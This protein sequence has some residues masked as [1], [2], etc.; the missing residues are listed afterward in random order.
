MK[1]RI[2][3]VLAEAGIASRRSCE[4]LVLQG[5]V[6]VNGEV[7]TRLP[8]M[9]DPEVDQVEIDDQRVQLQRRLNKERVYVLM[10]KP[11]GVYCTNVSQGEQ[12]R[13]IDLLPPD[14]N[15]RVYPVGR[16][17]ADSRG[18]LLLTNDGD[19]TQQLTH[20]KFGV[21]KTYT[22]IVDGFIQPETIEKLSEGIWLSDESGRGF[23]TGKT[24]IKLVKRTGQ[25]SVIQIT[26]KEDRNR[27]VRRMFAR[28]G[29]KVRELTRTKIGTLELGKLEPG[30]FRLLHPHEV[31]KLQESVKEKAARAPKPDKP[32]SKSKPAE[33]KR[34]PSR[35]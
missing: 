16:L 27:Q 2:Q 7:M 28:V 19:L 25:N 1:E 29:H 23:K 5:R 9:V 3:K 6:S 20:P 15:F 4:E 33:K 12:K 31:K 24:H 10:N 30:E 14:F 21:I 26:I 17:E 8:I 32:S 35:G 13:A 22:A 34:R 18:L 11:K